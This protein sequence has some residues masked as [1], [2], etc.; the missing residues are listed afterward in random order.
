MNR[1]YYGRGIVAGATHVSKATIIWL[2][3]KELI[4]T[5]NN[6]QVKTLFVVVPLGENGKYR[7]TIND[8]DKTHKLCID[9]KCWTD[10]F[11]RTNYK[12]KE[13]SFSWFD[14]KEDHP[15]ESHGFYVLEREV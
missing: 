9:E 11:N 14:I 3:E 1:K 2:E 4:K 10:I 13:F 6:L 12:L 7:S 5:M 8:F 15:Y